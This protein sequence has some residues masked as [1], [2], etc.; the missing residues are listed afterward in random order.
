MS[1]ALDDIEGIDFF[2]VVREEIDKINKFYTGKLAEVRIALEEILSK[3]GNIYLSH[4]TSGSDPTYVQRLKDIYMDIITLKQ[5]CELNTLGFTKIIKKYDKVMKEKTLGN[6]SEIIA[7]QPFANTEDVVQMIDIVTG[8]ISRDKLIEWD[9]FAHERNLKNDEDDLFPSVRWPG[10]CL[11]LSIFLASYFLPRLMG[12]ADNPATRMMAI[13][14]FVISMWITEAIPYFATA[15]TIPVLVTVLKVLKTPEDANSLMTTAEAA[16]Y[17]MSNIFNHTTMLLIGGYTI[18]SAFSRCQLELRV[19]SLLQNRFG[20]SPKLFILAVMFLGLFLSMWISNHTSPILCATIIL[21]IVRDLPTDSRFSKT[22]LLGLAY[23]CNFGGMMTPI[24]SLQN[25]LA[26]SYL[27]Q[28]GFNVS[29]GSWILVSVPFCV[30]CTV[31]AWMFL[32]VTVR[33]D[34]ITAIPVIVY[35]RKKKAF[36]R[37]NI[38]VVVLSLLT[39]VLF[40]SFSALSEVFGDIGIVALCF[41][42][43]MFGTG[44]L[45]EVDF[46]ALSW[47]TLFLVGGGNVLGKAIQSSGLLGFI[48]TGITIALPLDNPFIAFVL[49][50]C[51]CMT[52]ATF[53]SHTV[54][55]LI[56]LP[57]ILAVGQTLGMAEI[58]V[59]CSAFAVSGAM[60][61]PFSSFPNVNSLLIVD[62]FHRSYLST[63]DFIK[64]GLPMSIFTLIL[65]AT[66]G[67][68]LIN[69][70]IVK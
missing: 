15:L 11:S 55:S 21:P 41:V 49:I 56:L 44:M 40:A 61:L 58:V 64:T 62:D 29:F 17:V 19:A 16:T 13:L 39:I 9:L 50:L 28:A 26:V 63:P 48:S 12:L 14:L 46:N 2:A 27:Q 66:F 33:P 23:A 69:L 4:H 18:S 20:K 53:I 47:H 43:V 52:V 67:A 6:Y 10:L 34:D 32:V 30:L 1:I 59:M 57:I 25:V 51:F 36:G 22:L 60:G 31:L 68:L 37:R 3:T 45:S 65:I 5:F 7:R 38:A 35:E 70:I 24:S 42:V 8:L 54:A